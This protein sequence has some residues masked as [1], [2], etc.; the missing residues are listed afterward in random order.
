MLDGYSPVVI[1]PPPGHAPPRPARRG[2]IRLAAA[3]RR[4]AGPINPP[5]SQHTRLVST[6]RPWTTGALSPIARMSRSR[7]SR[8]RRARAGSSGPARRVRVRVRWDGIIRFRPLV[9]RAAP[10]PARVIAVP[11]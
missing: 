9:D 7:S 8:L 2:T 5:A 3:L 10:Y 4:G 6:S 11:L 1:V